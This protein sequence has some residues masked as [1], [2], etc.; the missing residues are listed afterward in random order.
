MK[1]VSLFSNCGA[2]NVGYAAAGFKFA[3]IAEIIKRRLVVA[4][5]NHPDAAA[6]HGDLRKTWP[7]AV[8]AFI[9]THGL[10]C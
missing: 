6:V 8:D 5:V 3:V 7:V 10:E 9:E 1:A 4:S 2:G